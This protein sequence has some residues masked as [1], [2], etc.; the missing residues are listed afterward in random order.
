MS[1]KLGC[2][3]FDTFH[4]LLRD[5][6]EKDTETYENAWKE[7]SDTEIDAAKDLSQSIHKLKKA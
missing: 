7:L 1:P 5:F 6:S 3:K 2:R 4:D